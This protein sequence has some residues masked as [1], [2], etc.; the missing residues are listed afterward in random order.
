MRQPFVRRG[1]HEVSLGRPAQGWARTINPPEG[2][3]K[4]ALEKAK[5][6]FRTTVARDV[7]PDALPFPGNSGMFLITTA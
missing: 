5:T 3:I 7:R 6:I 4:L 1:L 2:F